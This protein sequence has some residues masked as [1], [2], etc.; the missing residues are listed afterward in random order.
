MRLDIKVAD[1]EWHCGHTRKGAH[2]V[3]AVALR[4]VW[5]PTARA[6]D[7]ARARYDARPRGNEK[8]RVEDQ[9]ETAG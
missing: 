3:V 5:A 9:G 8:L 7:G 1:D 2:L 4:V 6:G